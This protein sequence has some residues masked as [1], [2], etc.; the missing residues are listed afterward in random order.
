MFVF[1]DLIFLGVFL[2]RLNTGG[3]AAIESSPFVI[4]TLYK[5]VP[6]H[7]RVVA[8]ARPQY[9]K[10][11]CSGPPPENKKY[12][13]DDLPGLIAELKNAKILTSEVPNPPFAPIFGAASSVFSYTA[14]NGFDFTQGF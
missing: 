6:F 11:Y 2:V 1:L 4:S 14:D 7:I 3:N 13:A 12:Q 5:K 9:G 8:H 10:W